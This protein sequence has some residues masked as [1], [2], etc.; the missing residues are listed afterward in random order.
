MAQSNGVSVLAAMAGDV[1]EKAAARPKA[2]KP[3]LST[4]PGERTTASILTPGRPTPVIITPAALPYDTPMEEVA[5]ILAALVA[6]RDSLNGV[7]DAMRLLIGDGEVIDAEK[8]KDAETT[9]K[10]LEREADR[11]VADAAK[12]AAG[13]E[14]AAA[15]VDAEKPMEA[16]AAAVSAKDR[17]R[18]MML[19]A[20]VDADA[21]ESFADRMARLQKEAQ[22]AA[23]GGGITVEPDGGIT[24]E[25][26]GGWTCPDHGKSVKKVSPRRGR[27]Y[28]GC[29]VEGCQQF[30]RL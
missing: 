13:D 20:M 25:P 5:R 23:F 1:M 18:A 8:V 17:K 28:R 12:A 29:P 30:E 22:A 27:E 2:P 10:L 9:Q 3:T 7:I 16:V 15:R 4:L 24:V 19:D 6:Q 11:R 26:D 21:T 14:R